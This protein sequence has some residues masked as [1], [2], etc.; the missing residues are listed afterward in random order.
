MLGSEKVITFEPITLNETVTGSALAT[1]ADPLCVAVMLHFP[2]PTNWTLFPETVQT[3]E[4]FDEYAKGSEALDV[5]VRTTELAPI[6]YEGNS[7]N[8]IRFRAGSLILCPAGHL[9]F[10]PFTFFVILPLMQVI[11]LPWIDLPMDLAVAA[12]AELAGRRSPATKI[13]TTTARAGF[14]LAILN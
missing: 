12:W 10:A 13:G 14:T 8:E 5:P 11:D 4:S 7:E 9:R 6:A 3:D 1:V 2:G